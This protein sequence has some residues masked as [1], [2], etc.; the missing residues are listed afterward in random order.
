MRPESFQ[1]TFGENPQARVLRIDSIVNRPAELKT[2]ELPIEKSA[3]FLTRVI[4]GAASVL[5]KKTA[6]ALLTTITLGLPAC[7]DNAVDSTITTPPTTI[8]VTSTIETSPTTRPTTTVPETTTTTTPEVTTT[9]PIIFNPTGEI[10]SEFL[11]FVELG[12]WGEQ[13]VY[14]NFNI[15]KLSVIILDYDEE[16]RSFGDNEYV[17]S[18]IT[19]GFENLKKGEPYIKRLMI[20]RP[21]IDNVF[22]YSFNDLSL[23]NQDV[24]N[25]A[26]YPLSEDL[27]QELKIRASQKSQI[28]IKIL[29]FIKDGYIP[30]CNNVG[31]ENKNVC[32]LITEGSNHL[33]TNVQ[34]VEDIENIDSLE[35]FNMD[36]N[37]FGWIYGIDLYPTEITLEN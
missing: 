19:V 36:A 8:P 25:F 16:V 26:N 12:L 1:S 11:K 18:F 29:T 17:T 35:S 27:I 4:S 23:V 3:G 32:E 6:I 10:Q 37:D 21:N 5:P 28:G 9:Q 34:I 33:N 14:P 24:G 22:E 20:G 7:G 13:E 31:P 2:V 30:D 15:Q